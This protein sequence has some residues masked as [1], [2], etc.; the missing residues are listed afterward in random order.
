M[1]RVNPAA[2]QS[3]LG[4]PPSSR[5]SP[6]LDPALVDLLEQTFRQHAGDDHHISV[7][8][9]RRSLRIRSEFLAQRIFAILDRDGNGRVNREE[10]LEAVRRLVFGSTRQKLRLAFQIHDLDGNGRIEPVEI[11]RM[12]ALN[13]AEEAG[14]DVSGVRS[15]RLR[16]T[17]VEELAKLFVLTADQDGDGSLSYEEFERIA[18]GDSR[19]LSLLAE[20]EASRLVP[21][22]E[23]LSPE[24]SSKPS[25][26]RFIRLLENRLPWVLFLSGWLVLNVLLAIRGALAHSAEGPYIMVARA[27]GA[28]LDLNGALILFTVMR[29]LL[30]RVRSTRVGRWLPLDDALSIHR[31][32]GHSIFVAGLV[33]T[34]AHFGNYAGKFGGTA[35]ALATKPVAQTGVGLVLL[36]CVMWVFSLPPIRKSGHFNLFYFAHFG[37]L[38]WF[39]L[40]LWHSA[41]FRAWIALPVLLFM[42]EWLL[43]RRRRA[44]P[45]EL[46]ELAGLSSGVTRVALARPA[47]FTHSA[48]DYAFLRIPEL[49]RHEWHPFTISSA[50]ER[51]HLTFHVR[52]QGDWTK[53]LRRLC[54]ARQA[55]TQKRPLEV[56]VDGPYGAPSAQIFAARHA[57]MIG[58]GIGV[59]PF[60]SVLESIVTRA[61][62]G[63]CPLEKL[64]FY[65]LNRESRSFEWFAELL[66]ELEQR[67]QRGLV[68]IQICMTGGRGNIA[69]LALNLARHLSYDI[70]KPDLVTGLRTQTRLSAPDFEAELRQ[71]AERHAPD[72]VEVFYC[73]PPGLGRKLKRICVSLGLR[74]RQEAF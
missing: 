51:E 36:S 61:N 49:A 43:R 23:L 62:A 37:Y 58:A 22:G 29:G 64:H 47:G 39:A 32:L 40:A 68:D 70:G 74:F 20:S 24:P 19:L 6:S 57:V 63:A 35:H 69:A 71:I 14:S 46:V 4:V 16:E 59:T 26:P 56:Y 27:A 65:W 48:G 42:G 21:D 2:K 10:F 73:G 52:T 8:D 38:A 67:D 1:L 33:H 15:T 72:P 7:E 53:A 31:L 55:D 25:S 30:T 45:A 28:T 5:Q 18:S 54:D 50:P 17:K 34:A 12:I 3:P 66:L 11:K 9:L 13:L 44:E 41:T 60:A